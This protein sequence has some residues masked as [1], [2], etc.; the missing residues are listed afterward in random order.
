VQK[1]ANIASALINTYQSATSAYA[2]QFTPIP[3]PDSPIR[4]GIAAGLAVAAGLANVAKIG[5]QKFESPSV[6][7]STPPSTGGLSGGIM[8]PSFNVVGN[9]GVNQLAQLQQ[10]PVQAYVVSGSVTTAQALD[11][12]RIENATL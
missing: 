7:S 8:S 2:S 12:N 3:T 1:A 10:T 4:G 6:D 5:Q 11:R 9:S